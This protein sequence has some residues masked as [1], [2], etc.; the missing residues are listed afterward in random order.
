MS[1]K[2]V[3]MGRCSKV[4]PLSQPR[5]R[6]GE[7]SYHLVWCGKHFR[8]CVRESMLL[9][10]ARSERKQRRYPFI[11]NIKKIMFSFRYRNFS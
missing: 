2:M 3:T 11:N 4:E 7:M 9:M 6:Y 8:E 5:L 1:G 10:D